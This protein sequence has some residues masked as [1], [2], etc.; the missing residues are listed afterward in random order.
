M[1][2]ASFFPRDAFGDISYDINILS[3]EAFPLI[4]FG[5]SCLAGSFSLAKFFL[6]GP[7]PIIPKNAPLL[8]LASVRFIT[9]FLLCTMAT[10]RMICL[11]TIF[12]SYYARYNSTT[13]EEEPSFHIPALITDPRLRVVVYLIP[14]MLTI[15]LNFGIMAKTGNLKDTFAI[16]SEY[17]QI[18]ISAGFTPFIFKY[19][20]VHENDNS[21]TNC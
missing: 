13:P 20:S 4:A 11:E 2:S 6:V 7:I 3:P 17:P 18:I 14:P 8:G 12:F 10:I 16:L 1:N 21:E 5:I 15:L 9:V 19:Q